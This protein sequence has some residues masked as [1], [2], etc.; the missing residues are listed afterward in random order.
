MADT[1]WFQITSARGPVECQH[2]VARL[3]PI[4]TAEA[5]A[6]GLAVEL[7]EAQDGQE[8]GT[9]RSAMLSLTGASEG[10]AALS[11][12]WIGSVLWTCKSPFRPHHRRQNWFVGVERFAVPQ[13]PVWHERD[14]EFS[15]LRASG[16]GGQHVNKTESAVRVLHRPTGLSVVGREERSQAQNKRLALARLAALLAEQGAQQREDADKQRWEK[17]NS[18]ERGNPVRTFTGPEFRERRERGG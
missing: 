11:E 16:P 10:L 4:L 8:S 18:L 6:A 13:Q 3:L 12:R 5:Q 17:H 2:V 7:I 1:F 14:L 9:L 15:T